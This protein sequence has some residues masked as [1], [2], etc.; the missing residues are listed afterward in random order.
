MKINYIDII[1]K[2]YRGIYEESNNIFTNIGIRISATK[3]AATV[4]EVSLTVFSIRDLINSLN[5]SY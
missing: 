4:Q 2:Q 1:D 3:L 5:V